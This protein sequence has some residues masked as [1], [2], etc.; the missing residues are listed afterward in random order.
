[1]TIFE[2][3]EQSFEKKFALDEELRFK[4]RARTNMLFGLWAAGQL[5]RSGA[6]ADA[7]ARSVVMADFER[8]GDRD[9]LHK[10]QADLEAAGQT[11]S[12]TDLRLRMDELLVRAAEEI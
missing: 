8:P 10:V 12:E 9:V 5:G 4:A 3:R 2:E 6:E 1:M 7:Y 11:I